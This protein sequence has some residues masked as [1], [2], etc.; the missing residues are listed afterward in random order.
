[1]VEASPRRSSLVARVGG[2]LV[3]SRSIYRDIADDTNATT[4]AGLIG[5][6]VA[7]L[8]GLAFGGLINTGIA[9]PRPLITLTAT[10]FIFLIGALIAWLTGGV[11]NAFVARTLFHGRTSTAEML[12]VFGF[13]SIFNL[14]GIFLPVLLLAWVLMLVGMIMGIR[15]AAEFGTGEAIITGTIA[16]IISLTIFLIIVGVTGSSLMVVLN[17]WG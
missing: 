5:A 3:F 10:A 2:V 1:V 17:M 13:A 9:S 4:T 16:G 12:R 7:L 8:T 11:V 15:E 14:I 6:L